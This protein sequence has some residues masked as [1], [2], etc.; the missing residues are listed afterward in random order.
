MPAANSPSTMQTATFSLARTLGSG[1]IPLVAANPDGS[2]FAA[3]FLSNGGAQVLL[4]DASLNP[5]GTYTSSSVNG[6]VF[7]RDGQSLY[8][9]ENSAAP[10]VITVLD[11]HS[12]NPI[13][14]VPDLWLAG[15]RSE[16]ED[17]DATKLLF[18]VANRGLAFVDAANPNS[19]PAAVPSFAAPPI[20]LPS[21]GPNVGGTSTV[22]AG[23]NFE[24][25]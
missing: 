16:I 18:G 5:A 11:G 2:R 10:P 24:A 4:L 1:T 9:S 13:G 6:M 22:L 7:S 19:L 8:V 15:K 14:Q 12:L 3:V 17:V 23:Q 20:A 21:E 25:T